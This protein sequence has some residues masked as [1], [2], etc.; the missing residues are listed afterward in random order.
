VP[1]EILIDEL[2]KVA[3][4]E[5]NVLAVVCPQNAESTHPESK[6]VPAKQPTDEGLNETACSAILERIRI[7]DQFLDIVNRLYCDAPSLFEGLRR[8]ALPLHADVNRILRKM[9]RESQQNAS[10]LASADPESPNP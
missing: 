10:R 7:N 6:P 9:L 1:L 4:R 3:A 8:K 5:A 2:N